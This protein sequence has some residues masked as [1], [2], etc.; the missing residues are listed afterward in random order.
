[1]GEITAGKIGRRIWFHPGDVVQELEFELLH[2]EAYGVNH[3]ARSGDPDGSVWF[4]DALAGGEPGAIEFV[5]DVGAAR[6]IPFAFVHA[7]HLAGVAGDA[8]VREKIGRVGEDQVHDAFA[9]AREDVETIALEDTDV[10]FLIA[11]DGFGKLLTDAR[12]FNCGC[13]NFG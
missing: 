7:D 10:M 3:V 8:V 4:Q 12:R 2:G 1:M 9:E 5:I 11:E 6:A 13:R